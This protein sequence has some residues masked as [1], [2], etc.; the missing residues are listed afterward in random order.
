MPVSFEEVRDRTELWM[1]ELFGALVQD[2]EAD[3]KV[4]VRLG[5]AVTETTVTPWGE[6]DHVVTT[7]ARVAT[8]ATLDE[9]LLRWLL[10]R[11]GEVVFGGFGLTPDGTVFYGHGIVASTCDREELRA[12]VT[13]VALVADRY[14]DEIVRRWGGK[15][16]ADR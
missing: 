6:N 9:E 11:N 2:P 15:R 7:R 8:G 10:L 1:R 3:G 12:S 16:A 4:R 5:S 14:D 13:S